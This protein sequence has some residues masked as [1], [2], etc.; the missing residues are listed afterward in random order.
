MSVKEKCQ[1][2]GCN[3]PAVRICPICEK[4][5]CSSHRCFNTVNCSTFK[6]A[7]WVKYAERFPDRISAESIADHMFNRLQRM[8]MLRVRS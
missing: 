5:V 8:K 4:K 2:E 7:G 3:N 1:C 6:P